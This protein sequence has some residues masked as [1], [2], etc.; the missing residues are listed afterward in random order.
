MTYATYATSE[1]QTAEN[2]MGKNNISCFTS[3]VP[4]D[5]Y[6]ATFSGQLA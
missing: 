1:M 2:Q 4:E 5:D 6:L 3:V